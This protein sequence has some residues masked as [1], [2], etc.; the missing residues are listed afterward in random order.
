MCAVYTMVIVINYVYTS[1]RNNSGNMLS[2]KNIGYKV[3]F[4]V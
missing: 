2:F 3:R 4:Y 1:L